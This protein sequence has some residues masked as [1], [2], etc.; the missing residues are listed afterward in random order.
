M[1]P[2]QAATTAEAGTPEELARLAVD[3]L[4]QARFNHGK[5]RTILASSKKQRIS[6]HVRNSSRC[7]YYNIDF[8][9]FRKEWTGSNK[10][11]TGFLVAVENFTNKLFAP[12]AKSF[13]PT[14]LRKYSLLVYH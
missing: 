6:I 3:S 1:V 4:Q 10:G 7:L 13:F 9:E 2:S 11:C 8:A 14:S 12:A 5:Q